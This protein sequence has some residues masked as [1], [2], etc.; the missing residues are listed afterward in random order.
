MKRKSAILPPE[1]ELCCWRAWGEQGTWG[2]ADGRGRGPAPN[3][4]LAGTGSP[5]PATPRP[6]PPP[7]P[8][9]LFPSRKW[10]NITYSTR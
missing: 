7:P 6:P 4:P 8:T 9:S 10:D 5:P 2:E 3:L 1:K